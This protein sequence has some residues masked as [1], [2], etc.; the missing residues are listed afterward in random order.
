MNLV[1]R[2]NKFYVYV[3]LDPRK[4]GKYVYGDYSFDYEPFYVGKGKGKRCNEIK[5]RRK[6]SMLHGKI[7]KIKC[8]LILKAEKELTEKEAFDL[9]RRLISLIGRYDLHKGPLANLTDGGDGPS[10]HIHTKEQRKKLSDAH[11]G[12]IPWNKGKKASK[13]ARLHL[14]LSHRGERPWL[15]G[16]ALS[17]EHKKKIGDGN[18]GKK[19]TEEH[20]RRLLEAN[21]GRS[22]SEEQ[23]KK[24]SDTMKRVH[25]PLC[26]KKEGL[27]YAQIGH[28]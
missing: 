11:K 26:R 5:T 15:Q 17:L 28:C 21:L 13:E 12:Q 3:Y 23:R 8:P 2:Q 24:I 27:F 18:R 4:P 9:E 25:N 7:G 6:G 14:S 19:I 1:K 20:K 10:G 16:K 22:P